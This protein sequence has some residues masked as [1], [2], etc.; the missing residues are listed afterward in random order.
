[1]VDLSIIVVCFDNA[2][3]V[4]KTLT[5]ISLASEKH[6]EVI[7]VDGSCSKSIYDVFLSF[8]S[9]EKLLFKCISEPD[10]GIYDAM[11]KGVANSSGKH[12]VFMNSGD[13]FADNAIK[14]FFSTEA[15]HDHLYYGDVDFYQNGEMSFRFCS[16]MRSIFDFLKHN[17]FSHQA[18]YYPSESI[19]RLGA[20]NLDYKVSADFELT[21]RFFDSGVMFEKINGI[22]AY[23]E[24][25]GISCQ[26][27]VK[28]YV[29]RLIALKK[30]HHYLLSFLLLVYFPIFYFKNRIVNVLDGSAALV[31]Y[32]KIKS[33][34]L[35]NA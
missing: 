30:A 12:V 28:S 5:S 25:G 6:I 4:S 3:D 32:R 14:N 24:L 16:S 17:C 22:F 21:L 34:L 15:K 9:S 20:Y 29:E 35:N 10:S 27:G 26:R 23:C 11:N 19:R 31:A 13:C 18:I 8:G 2:D 1:V 33:R 7:I